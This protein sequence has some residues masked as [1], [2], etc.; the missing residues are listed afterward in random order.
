MKKLLLA[1][2]LIAFFGFGITTASVTLPKNNDAIE[3]KDTNE[4]SSNTKKNVSCE[5]S[6]ITNDNNKSCCQKSA[7]ES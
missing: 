5:K 4:E 2:S 6:E 3:K 1:F 7:N